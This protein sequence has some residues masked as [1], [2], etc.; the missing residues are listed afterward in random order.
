M[1]T[2]DYYGILGLAPTA[3]PDD[4]KEAY[5]RLAKLRHPDKNP[6]DPNATANFQAVSFQWRHSYFELMF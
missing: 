5:R 4:V 2:A 3:E 1:E 6:N